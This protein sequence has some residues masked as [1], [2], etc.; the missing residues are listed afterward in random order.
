MNFLTSL[1][2]LNTSTDNPLYA[3]FVGGLSVL[4]FSIPIA[5]F[6]IIQHFRRKKRVEQFSQPSNNAPGFTCPVC[7]MTNDSMKPCERCGFDP[8]TKTGHENY[9]DRNI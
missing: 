8:F 7:H 6:V 5:I 9:I 4:L 1:Y 3:G 2:L